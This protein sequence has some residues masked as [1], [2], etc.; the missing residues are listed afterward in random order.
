[1]GVDAAAWLVGVDADVCGP[2]NVMF[3]PDSDSVI[4]CTVW[5]AGTSKGAYFPA[6]WLYLLN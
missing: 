5:P 3:K 1:M 4:L 6:N 2:K